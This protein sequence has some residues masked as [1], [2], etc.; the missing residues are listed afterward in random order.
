ML[1]LRMIVYY[2]CSGLVPHAFASLSKCTI[3]DLQNN[4]FTKVEGVSEDAFCSS[5]KRRGS[6]VS[7][8]GLP[9]AFEI[10]ACKL[11]DYPNQPAHS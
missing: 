2:Y 3:V 7:S 11:P 10:N 9:P 1:F 8:S 6:G 4:N 5:D